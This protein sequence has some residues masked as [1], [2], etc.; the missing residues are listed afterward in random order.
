MILISLQDV[1]AQSSASPKPHT[2]LGLLV[3]SL[4]K[5]PCLQHHKSWGTGLDIRR[6]FTNP[7]LI[8]DAAE[9]GNRYQNAL[10]LLLALYLV[11]LLGSVALNSSA[12]PLNPPFPCLLVTVGYP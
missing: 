4:I 9:Q 1:L 6:S 2:F 12:L 11:E 3:P 7:P 8:C 5:V 10:V